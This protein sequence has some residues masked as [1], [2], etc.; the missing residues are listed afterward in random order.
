MLTMGAPVYMSSGR[1]RSGGL[2][3]EGIVNQHGTNKKHHAELLHRD[4][5]LEG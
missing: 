3:V 1:E 2:G 5:T 4:E